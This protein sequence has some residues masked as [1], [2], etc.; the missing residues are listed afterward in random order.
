MTRFLAIIIVILCAIIGGLAGALISEKAH[1]KNYEQ[2]I[3]GDD[4]EHCKDIRKWYANAK[5]PGSSPYIVSCC[6][7]GDAYWVETISVGEK[8]I[9]VKIVDDRKIQNRMVRDGQIIFVPYE[10]FDD[11]QQGNP[12]GHEIIFL[13]GDATT[14]YCFFP[15]GG[16]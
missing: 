3:C 7:E 4:D 5:T 8:G 12:T 11:K 1:G 14:V 6:G 15:N 2:I 16:V 10:R 13:S 9:R